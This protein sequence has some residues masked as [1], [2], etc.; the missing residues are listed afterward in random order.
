M[1]QDFGTLRRRDYRSPA[2]D[3]C[4]KREGEDAGHSERNPASSSLKVAPPDLHNHIDEVGD[5]RKSLQGSYERMHVVGVYHRKSSSSHGF[6]AT[7]REA[8][9]RRMRLEARLIA[10]NIGMYFGRLWRA[11][12]RRI[13]ERL[14]SN[15]DLVTRA[16]NHDIVHA[17]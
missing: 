3:V 10:Q 9:R 8:E 4:D 1:K 14:G 13:L 11:W 12:W 16:S 5:D 17:E 7:R 6:G 2:F 15:L